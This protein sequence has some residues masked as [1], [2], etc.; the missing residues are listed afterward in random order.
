[1][2]TK[3]LYP[4]FVW[5]GAVLLPT[6][7]SGE[8]FIVRRLAGVLQ[9]IINIIISYLLIIWGLQGLN[10]TNLL[11]INGVDISFIGGLLLLGLGIY[12]APFIVFLGFLAC[13]AD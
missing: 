8:R 1:M 5:N 13:I 9:L 7:C 10:I 2:E 4:E 6:I 11:I 12:L 3:F